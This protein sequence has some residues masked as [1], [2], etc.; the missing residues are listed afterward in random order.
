MSC[1]NVQDQISLRFDGK[2]DSDEW[3]KS[4]AHIRSCRRCDLHFRSM[5]Q[6]R[7]GLADM[8]RIHPPAALTA[9]L[10]VMASHERVRHAAHATWSS[11]FEHWSSD[12]RLFFDNL[13]RPFAVPVTGGLFAALVL[14]SILVP[15]LN[16]F[17][18]GVFDEPPLAIRTDPD[19]E[20]VGS[21]KEPLRLQPGSA[22]ITGNEVSLV[23]IIDERGHVQDYYLSGGELTYEMASLILL[24]RFT[25][26]TV[27]G[28]PTWGLKQVVFPPTVH[29]RLRS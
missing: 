19:G 13:M 9:R 29:R 20:I 4:L 1:E 3:E 27:D 23:L 8:A 11:R 24:S 7:A 25:P 28:Q 21:T 18:R 16:P 15:T 12:I 5:S 17:Q 26:A 22:T 14:F 2:V 6:L 10:R